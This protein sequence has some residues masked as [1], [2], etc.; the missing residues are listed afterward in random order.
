MDLA[1]LTEKTLDLVR[2]DLTR[3]NVRLET[4]FAP[5][6]P[7]AQADPQQLQQ[8][9]LNLF[10][11]AIQAMAGRPERWLRVEVRGEGDQLAVRVTDGGPGIAADVLPR[12]FDPF[13]STKARA[14]ASASASA[15]R[16]PAR[17]A[18]T[19]GSRARS[20]AA[21]R[22]RCSCRSPQPAA[23]AT[24]E[25]V[26]LVDDDPDVA[27]ALSAM[28]AKEGLQVVARR[29]R[30]GGLA[31]LEASDWDAVFLDVRLP[32]LSGPEIYARLAATRAPSWRSASCSSP[33]ASGAATAACA[34]SCRRSR[35][36][37]SRVRRTE[38]RAVLRGSCA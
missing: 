11:N 37:P 5:D 36:S 10:T 25:R 32:D 19:C 7:P 29:H 35:S 31:M 4:A 2:H 9:L 13:F 3:Q 33:A 22:S 1:A 27:E 30:R 21:P 16:S 26:L 8:V 38:V 28:L 17:T 23:W 12:I 14:A 6:L 20:G 18:A 34:R 24:L 15:T